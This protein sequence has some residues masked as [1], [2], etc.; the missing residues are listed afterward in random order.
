MDNGMTT[1]VAAREGL[2]KAEQ[3]MLDAMS[4]KDFD[5]MISEKPEPTVLL[6]LAE[7][8]WPLGE[9]GEGD[10]NQQRA[11]AVHVA[12]ATAY[13]TFQSKHGN[14]PGTTHM[15]Q[16]MR[17]QYHGSLAEQISMAP[18][19]EWH[20]KARAYLQSKQLQTLVVGGM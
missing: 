17:G 3:R 5:A 13:R 9:L 6:K 10:V 20:R 16:I 18:L 14:E 1:R 8:F 19:E 12:R 2:S 15:T 11:H 7:K 4:P